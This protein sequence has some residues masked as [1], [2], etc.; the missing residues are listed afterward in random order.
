[1]TDEIAA[2]SVSLKELRQ[3]ARVRK[4]TQAITSTVVADMEVQTLLKAHLASVRDLSA[5]RPT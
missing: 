5:Y 2:M 3:K 1:M 4:C